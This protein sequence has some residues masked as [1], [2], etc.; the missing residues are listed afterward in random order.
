MSQTDNT[1][2][3]TQEALL[4]Q[5]TTDGLYIMPWKLLHDGYEVT[6]QDTV[7]RVDPDS[8]VPI[9]HSRFSAGGRIISARIFVDNEETFWLWLAKAT[10]NTALKFWAYDPKLS[11]FMRCIFTEQPTLSPAGTSVTGMY[12]QL[13][14][15]AQ[16][17]SV[18][19]RKFITE[20]M[21][22]RLVIEGAENALVYE[23][24]EVM[25]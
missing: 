24:D 10:R 12:A 5:S 19:I 23:S 18:P 20:N 13:K 9:T 2:F 7:V 14:L 6:R 11:G 22:E 21:P 3:D 4:V 8:G 1:V 17:N 16:S 25:Y 15:Y